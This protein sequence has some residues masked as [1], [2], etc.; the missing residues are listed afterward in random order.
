MGDPS[1]RGFDRS[2]RRYLKDW[3]VPGCA[4]GVVKD[5][6]VV[7]A[8]GFGFRDLRRGLSVT[9]NTLFRI[10]SCTKAFTAVGVGIL[11]D[12]G[13]LAWN[14]PVRKY[15]PSFRLRDPVATKQTTLR[16]ILC[17]RTGMGQHSDVWFCSPMSRKELLSKLA[18][19]EPV[20][21]FRSGF[22]YSGLMY[23]IAGLVIERVTGQSWEEFTREHVLD[24]LGMKSSYCLARDG[25]ASERIRR[26]QAVGYVKKGKRSVP[27]FHGEKKNSSAAGELGPIGPAGSIVSNVTDTCRWLAALLSGGGNGSFPGLSSGSLREICTPQVPEPGHTL[28]PELLDA[29]H[30]MGWRVQ[31][32]RGLRDIWHGGQCCGMTAGVSFLPSEGIGVVVLTNGVRHPLWR[33]LPFV[34]YDRILGLEPIRWNNRFR[35]AI[36]PNPPVKRAKKQKTRKAGG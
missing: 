14:M 1:L 9:E 29:S 16:D 31:P 6:R 32:Y 25:D 26:E 4:V 30:A 7:F 2:V 34:I 35:K 11:V 10:G 21:E 15:L 28:F 23:A 24:P 36:G 5:S 12:E 18:D 3:G 8:K 22:A 33:M 13:R 27:Y 17:H 19:L 20:R